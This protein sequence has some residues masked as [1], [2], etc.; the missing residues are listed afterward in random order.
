[1]SHVG[2]SLKFSVLTIQSAIALYDSALATKD[3]QKNN[4]QSLCLVSLFVA[5]KSE[6]SDTYIPHF[7]SLIKYSKHPTATLRRME[8]ELLSALKWELAV[9]TPYHYTQFYIAHGIVYTGDLIKGKKI[10]EKTARYIRKY[11][12]F[13][14]ELCL[15]E[16]EL[17]QFTPES[18]A[19]ACLAGA[20]K[21]VGVRSV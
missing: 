3:F 6:E 11:T 21:A 12:E 14:V 13:F 7:R 20:R 1:M 15:Q 4:L 19:C 2:E 9:V 10:N 18:L 16:Y 17:Y 8:V 5:A